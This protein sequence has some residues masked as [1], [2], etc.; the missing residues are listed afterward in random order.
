MLRYLH[1]V[2]ET[3]WYK[4]LGP[5]VPECADRHLRDILSSSAPANG[6]LKTSL[7]QSKA[8]LANLARRYMG[9]DTAS[10]GA[11]ELYW[12]SVAN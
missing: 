9:F 7:A 8:M 1:L 11:P 12:N 2:L 10:N 4:D 3:A 6:H 5:T